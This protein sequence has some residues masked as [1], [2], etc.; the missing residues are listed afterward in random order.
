MSQDEA[1]FL[2]PDELRAYASFREYPAPE[3]LLVKCQSVND[4]RTDGLHVEATLLQG[5]YA[6]LIDRALRRRR[7]LITEPQAWVLRRVLLGAEHGD[8]PPRIG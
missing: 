6:E 5:R 1:L 2:S 7:P 4:L 3:R 8:L